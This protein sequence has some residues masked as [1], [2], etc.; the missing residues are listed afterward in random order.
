MV[1]IHVQ[2]HKHSIE[3]GLKIENKGK[4]Y[5]LSLGHNIFRLRSLTCL[6]SMNIL[7]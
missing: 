5:F 4:N 3:S 1:H 7:F 6:N 2:Q